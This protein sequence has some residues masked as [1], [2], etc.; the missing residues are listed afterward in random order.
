MK[1]IAHSS[2]NTTIAA[3]VVAVQKLGMR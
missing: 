3:T 1:A 2:K